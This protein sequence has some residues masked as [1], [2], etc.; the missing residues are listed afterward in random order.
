MLTA[1]T[2]VLFYVACVVMALVRHPIYGLYLYL[3]EVYLHPPS[4]WWGAWLPDMRWSM[5][6]AC[7]TLLAIFIKRKDLPQT[8]RPWYSTA[9]GVGLIVLVVWFWIQ[10]L[11]ALDPDFHLDASILLSKYIIVFYIVYRLVTTPRQAA[12][13]LLVHVIGCF[14]LGL[15]CLM[16]DASRA[17]GRLDGVGGPNLDDANSL[18]MFLGTGVIAGAV[19]FL[20]RTGWRRAVV[21]LAM[22][23]ILNGLILTGSRGA[24]LGVLVA[25]F[26]LIFLRPPQRRALFWGAAALGIVLGTLLVDK[27]FVERMFTI[28]DAVEQSEDIDSSAE[29]RIVLFNAQLQM[30]LHYP[31]GAG[32]R[33]TA[34]LSPQYMDSKWLT[35]R[36]GETQDQAARA[37]HNTFMTM[38]VEQGIPGAILYLWMTF[39]GVRAILEVRRAI[40]AGVALD[41]TAPAVACCAGIVVV[42]VAGQTADYLKTEVQVWLL[43]MLAGALDRIRLALKSSN[44]TTGSSLASRGPWL[45]QGPKRPATDPRPAV[46]GATSELPMRP[47][48]RWPGRTPAGGDR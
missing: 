45:H 29:S 3:A 16:N 22:P 21:V 13:T 41:L 47:G 30:A 25:G 40:R 6:A 32:H 17:E 28:K 23:L 39:W 14:F 2:F 18:G 11:W 9:P 38:L 35:L 46:R 20:W 19:L 42:W 44:A 5:L 36:Q 27:T 15:L 31:H 24:F 37:S 33:G 8:V 4:R 48:A 34:V 7:V 10:W 43:A 12:D 1:G 26:V